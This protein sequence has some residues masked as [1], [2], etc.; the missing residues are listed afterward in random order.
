MKIIEALRAEVLELPEYVAGKMPNAS[1]TGRKIKLASNENAFGASPLA[2]EA[3][4]EVLNESLRI[5]PDSRMHILRNA[6]VEFW[7]QKRVDLSPDTL[8]FGDGSGEILSLIMNAFIDHDDEIVLPQNSFSLYRLIGRSRGG[9]ITEIPRSADY[10]A[11]IRAMAEHSTQ[12]RSKML[13][14]ANPDNPTSTFIRLEDIRDM[15]K[16]I[17]ETTA[18]LVD[19][20]YMHFA[21]LENSAIELLNDFP[22]LTVSFTFSKAYG[23][24]ALRVGYAVMHPQIAVHIEKLRLPF[25]LGLLQQVGATAALMDNDFLEETVRL[26]RE[27]IDYLSS[28]FDRLGI[29]YPY[30]FGNFF[31][32]DLGKNYGEVFTMLSDNG[33]SIRQLASF[34]FAPNFARINIGTMEENEYLIEILEQCPLIY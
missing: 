1:A 28:Q 23:L 17:P 14:L 16:H 4:G 9:R 13:I 10:R 12:N 2:L 34:G 30:P 15:M 29:P 32:V 22:N 5:Y 27:G 19:E 24:A 21:G 7:K 26:T 11:D 20:A 33:I 25:N 31:M 3:M 8:L 6:V 18:V